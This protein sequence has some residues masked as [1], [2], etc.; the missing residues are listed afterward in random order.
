MIVFPL[1]AT[2]ISLACALVIGR[3]TLRR[4]KPDRIV[5]TV[6][7]AVF[8]IAAG[9][10]VVGSLSN[11]TPA[12]ARVYYVTGAVL[13]VGYLALGELYLLAGSRIARVAP[14]VTL[15]ITAVAITLVLDAP[16]D[17]AML[18]ED[19]WRALEPGAGLT[20]LT[21]SINSIGTVVLVGGAL[22]S[23][24]RFR[25]LGIQG[26]RMIGCILIAAGTIMVA[27][28]GT[29]T[30]FG[31]HEYLYIAMSFGV[32]TIFAGVLQTRRPD[33]PRAAV[34]A[35]EVA[36]TELARASNGR[37]AAPPALKQT[38]RADGVDQVDPGIVYVRERLLS[39]P[40]S[41]LAETCATWSVTPRPIDH[42][43]RDEARLVW[44]MRLRLPA[45]DQP[46]FDGLSPSAQLQIAELY[47]DI[48]Q[49]P[50]PALQSA[51]HSELAAI[52]RSN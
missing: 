16:I 8:A 43:S 33:A 12:L 32:A 47:F 36:A 10:E 3:D 30:R 28:G 50:P 14:G 2:L 49:T 20:A 1:F 31:Q 41:E 42:F 45:A 15:L 23:A 26:Y 37:Q 18:A 40:E 11:W 22:Y 34:P 38:A 25:R 44:A 4:P 24:W 7:F 52:R 29:L 5:W 13:V 46:A 51:S 48:F 35:G 19:G 39:L 21:I 17:S 9:A 6:A 27:L